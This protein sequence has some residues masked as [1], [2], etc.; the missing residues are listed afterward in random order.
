MH[1]VGTRS[2]ICYDGLV[3]DGINFNTFIVNI[4]FI[5][6]IILH[7]IIMHY[8]SVL[9]VLFIRN[10]EQC[11]WLVSLHSSLWCRADI[12][13]ELDSVRLKICFYITYL[14]G[15]RLLL[16]H[17]APLKKKRK[18]LLS[19]SIHLP[20]ERSSPCQLS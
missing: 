1:N 2:I 12:K 17:L 16:F 9:Y 18:T 10:S 8:Y 14:L 20:K 7:M 15:S 11:Y 5:C 13:L 3:D 19:Y 4:V 6:Y